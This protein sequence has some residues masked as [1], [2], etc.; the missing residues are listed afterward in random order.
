MNACLDYSPSRVELLC[1]RLTA[2]SKL[3]KGKDQ[4]RASRA[5]RA[6]DERGLNASVRILETIAFRPAGKLYRVLTAPFI[7]PS[8]QDQRNKLVR[9]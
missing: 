6:R 3:R 8:W 9:R 2:T 4:L 5:S 7:P 1:H